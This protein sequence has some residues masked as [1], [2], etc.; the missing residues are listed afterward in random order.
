MSNFTPINRDSLTPIENVGV[1]FS[2]TV[3]NCRGTT[4]YDHHLKLDGAE[5]QLPGYVR[6]SAFVADNGTIQWRF[7]TADGPLARK[8]SYKEP[9]LT[10]ETQV[11]FPAEAVAR[12]RQLSE[13][14][15]L[16]SDNSWFFS[17]L[18][19]VETELDTRQTAR[20]DLER[21]VST[22]QK[23][24]SD[25]AAP[26]TTFVSAKEAGLDKGYNRPATAAET[27]QSR[28]TWTA[29]IERAQTKL[30]AL[31]EEQG[32]RIALLERLRIALRDWSWHKK[33]QKSAYETYLDVLAA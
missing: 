23:L 4:G 22:L 31:N 15:H 26:T 21:T 13:E 25:P 8:R 28:A 10:E 6:F 12:M 7:V 16:R 24:L 3:G 11:D 9:K 2:Q 5:R 30:S 1:I 19:A 27:A 29:N 33:P 14:M 32:E 17:A 20:Y 18:T